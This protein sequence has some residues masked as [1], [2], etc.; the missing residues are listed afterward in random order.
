MRAYL[1]D[2]GVLERTLEALQTAMTELEIL[3]HDNDWFVSDSLETL[4]DSYNELDT[5]AMTKM[6]ELDEQ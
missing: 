6:D 4:R 1:I 5:E 2:K 3:E